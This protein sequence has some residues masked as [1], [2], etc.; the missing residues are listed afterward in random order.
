MTM[1]NAFREILIKADALGSTLRDIL[2]WAV[3]EGAPEKGDHVLVSR[4]DDATNDL[5]GVLHEVCALAEP[6]MRTRNDYM[7]LRQ[8]L[9]ECH[10]YASQI[11]R[12]FYWELY[13]PEAAEALQFL[14]I[15][16]PDWRAWTTGVKDALVR[17]R[18]P[19]EELNE[20]MLQAWLEL[21]DRPGLAAHP[22]IRCVSG[23]AP[24]IATS[25]QSVTSSQ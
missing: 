18:P 3:I 9:V 17:C 22:E 15:E 20:S 19:I 12:R 4:Y 6:A 10:Q 25:A 1:Q 14:Q 21:S 2:R 7:S 16:S 23:N 11:A 24:T 5:L 8:A 13:S